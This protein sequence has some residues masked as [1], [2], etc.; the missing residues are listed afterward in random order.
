MNETV[1]ATL[2]LGFILGARHALEPDHV[3]AVS[4]II[5]RNKSI[6]RSSLAGTLWGLGHTASLLICGCIVLALRQGIPEGLVVWLET[7]VAVM[8]VLLGFNALRTSVRGWKFHVH[9]HSHGGRRHFH[10]HIHRPEDTAVHEHRHIF[11]IG[12]RSFFVGMVHG[13]AGSGALMVLVL[14]TVPTILAGLTYILLFGL[15][16]VG[17]MLML[18]SLVSIPFVLSAR[19]YRLFN[20]GL[21]IVASLTS[22]ALGLFWISQHG[23]V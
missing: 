2:G 14:A 12:L 11:E 6:S 10:F 7:A 22:I 8:L 17:G 15:G 16:S 23:P 21:Q 19:R 9:V 3:A 5:S 20:Q 4:T 18:S 1:L 13:L